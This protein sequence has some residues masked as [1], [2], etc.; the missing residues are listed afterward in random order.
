MRAYVSDDDL[1]LYQGDASVVL[2]ELP[3][4]SFQCVVTSPPYWVQRDDEGLGNEPTPEA[5]VAALLD[6]LRGVHRVLRPDGCLWLN[7]GDTFVSKGLVGI[8]WRVALALQAEGWLLRSD[9]V[10]WK[11]NAVCESVRDRPSK[12]HEYVFLLTRRSRYY[13]DQEAVREPTSPHSDFDR[14]R[15]EHASPYSAEGRRATSERLG[16]GSRGS[17]H[18]RNVRDVWDITTTPYPGAHFSVMAVEVARRCIAASTSERGCC[19][20]CGQPWQRLVRTPDFAEQP[21]RVSDRW[22]WRN[23][24]RTSAGQ[25]W[26]E[27]RDENP[28]V[29]LGWRPDCEHDDEPV[30]CRVLDPF[31][32]A[33]TTALAARQLGRHATLVELSEA[34]CAMSAERL[35]QL[36]LLATPQLQLVLDEVEALDEVVT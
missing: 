7:L 31:G 30:P 23:G 27:W 8:P 17:A 10:W 28:N 9:V 34:Y 15:P 19:P 25:A 18:G 4:E 13:W 16:S 29:T 11:R 22:G 3:A 12:A 14:P 36:S 6:V 2:A 26:Q 20:Q 32:G 5:Y 1:T 35:S 33:G 24:D 21:K